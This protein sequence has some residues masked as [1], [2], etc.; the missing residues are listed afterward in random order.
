MRCAK[1]RAAHAWGFVF[2]DAGVGV[3]LA[4]GDVEVVTDG[5]AADREQAAAYGEAAVVEQR[6]S[7]QARV[8]QLH[9]SLPVR[10]QFADAC[11]VHL[12]EQVGGTGIETGQLDGDALQ[13][14]LE[15]RDAFRIP[16]WAARQQG[17]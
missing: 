10:H 9:H 11:R 14:V 6:C 2:G 3:A 16:C 13:H 17:A 1:T 15:F 12:V 4:F 5:L 7:A 8:G